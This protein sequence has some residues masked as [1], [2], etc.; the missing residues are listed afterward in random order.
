MITLD[1]NFTKRIAIGFL[2]TILVSFLIFYLLLYF[3]PTSNGLNGLQCIAQNMLQTNEQK[4]C[5]QY[6]LSAETICIFL[7][8]AIILLTTIYINPLPILFAEK[9]KKN[10]TIVFATILIVIAN[11]PCINLLSDINTSTILHFI[12]EDS[13]QWLAYKQSESLINSLLS[14]DMVFVEIVCMAIL[15]AISEE[16][17]FRGFLQQVASDITKHKNLA[18]I[19]IAIIFSLLHGDIFNFIPRFVLGVFL[20]Y[21]FAYTKNIIF[22][23]IAH[24][25]HNTLVVITSSYYNDMPEIGTLSNMPML[26]IISAILLT[27]FIG[28]LIR[29]EE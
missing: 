26:G 15:P 10:T 9:V 21:L 4:L 7:L 8:P 24:C 5:V 12:G 29:N 13:E 25:C 18:I 27:G 14:T 28:F 22:P 6:I 2:G 17:F 19:L 1:K 3:A 16:L 20:G 11:I 23:I